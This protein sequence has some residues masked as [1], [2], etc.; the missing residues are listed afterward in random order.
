MKNISLLLFAALISCG[1]PQKKE[2]ST[3]EAGNNKDAEIRSNGTETVKGFTVAIPE[4]WEV[5]RDY[6]GTDLMVMSPTGITDSF[7]ENF[8]VIVTTDAGGLSLDDYYTQ[9]LEYFRSSA[10][11]FEMLGKGSDRINGTDVLWMDYK[12]DYSD[13]TIYGK[14]Y[15][16]L[17]DNKAYVITYSGESASNDPMKEIFSST[18]KTMKFQ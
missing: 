4:G 7:R 15:Y 3:G 16:A 17:K 1:S 14:Q 5:Q 8:N 12:F 2:E 10:P 11:N 9:S 18:V 6:E 13:R